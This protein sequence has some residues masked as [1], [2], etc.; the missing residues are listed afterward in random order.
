MLLREKIVN[1]KCKVEILLC[2]W[3]AEKGFGGKGGSAFFVESVG[4]IAMG[5]VHDMVL[6]YV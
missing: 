5:G 4:C 3:L 1:L 6:T 2:L